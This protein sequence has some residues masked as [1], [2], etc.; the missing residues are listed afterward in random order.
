MA[1]E[2]F[3]KSAVHRPAKHGSLTG[4]IVKAVMAFLVRNGYRTAIQYLSNALQKHKKSE[5]RR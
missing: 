4:P 1:E 5:K 2:V 3:E